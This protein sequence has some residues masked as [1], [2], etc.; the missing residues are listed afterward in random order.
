MSASQNAEF[1]S[2]STD[3]SGNVNSATNESATP[4]A[5]SISSSPSLWAPNAHGGPCEDRLGLKVRREGARPSP[6]A[7]YPAVEITRVDQNK[8]RAM[9]ALHHIE[10]GRSGLAITG[11]TQLSLAAQGQASATV[12][13]YIQ[14]LEKRVAELQASRAGNNGHFNQ[15]T[16]S[17]VTGSN[18]L[19][20]SRK[21]ALTDSREDTNDKREE[22]KAALHSPHPPI[23]KPWIVEIKRYKKLNYR[24]GSAGLYD[25]AENIEEI[26]ARESAARGGGYVIKLYREHDCQYLLSIWL[27]LS[28]FRVCRICSS[29]GFGLTTEYFAFLARLCSDQN[30]SMVVP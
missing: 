2:S 5:S 18:E 10:R 17:N 9:E 28:R 19:N 6:A 26:R 29:L 22:W 4:A 30:L 14:D 3:S 11:A 15:I 20:D 1:S 8:Q 25:E 12:L 23:S 7:N 27:L 16:E 21:D 13:N 24:F